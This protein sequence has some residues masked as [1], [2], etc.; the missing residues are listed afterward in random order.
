M[1][2]LYISYKSPNTMAENWTQYNST[3]FPYSIVSE[4]YIILFDDFKNKKNLTDLWPFF[5]KGFV[6]QGR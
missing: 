2:S 1:N 4:K 6:I 3:S 5:G